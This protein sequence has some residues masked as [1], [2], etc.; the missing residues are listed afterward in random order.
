V[1]LEAP[2]LHQATLGFDRIRLETPEQI[3]QRLSGELMER[4]RETEK[5]SIINR[6]QRWARSLVGA[7]T[8]CEGLGSACSFAVE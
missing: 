7:E 6:P 1:Y 4:P 3:S 2:R 8:G 5:A